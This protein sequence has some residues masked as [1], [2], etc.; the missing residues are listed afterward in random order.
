ME[1]LYN[2]IEFAACLVDGGLAVVFLWL[3]CGRKKHISKCL[4]IVLSII[5]TLI[6]GC[7]AH[8]ITTMPIQL[9]GLLMVLSIYSYFL[10]YGTVGKKTYF[11]ILWNVLLMMSSF[12]MVYGLSAILGIPQDLITQPASTTRVL[13]LI[14]HKSLL[15]CIMYIVFVYNK[16]YKFDYKQWLITVA[17]FLSVLSVGAIFIEL[18]SR[19]AFDDKSSFEIVLIAIILSIM[20]VVVCICQHILNIQNIYKV[21][22]DRLKSY[23]E[24]EEHDIKR[25]EEMYEASSII[26]HD[27]KHY[28]LVMNN[29][30]EEEKYNDLK[31]MIDELSGDRLL[32]A[33]VI[34]T[35]DNSLNA[36]LNNKLAVCKQ[37]G[38]EFQVQISCKI[39]KEIMIDICVIM[40]NLLDN[41]IEAEKQEGNGYI[42]TNISMRGNMLCINVV[43]KIMKPVL[44]NNPRLDTTKK[45]KDRHGF[46]LRSVSRRVEELDGIYT[47]KEEEGEFRT[48][49]QIPVK[50]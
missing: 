50:L 30:L 18:Y 49:I 10:L 4:H 29:M 14:I 7:I 33:N 48:I 34:Y 11:I 22:N 1:L 6:M 26:R 37:N 12:F 31:T 2:I 41:A 28:A 23:L 21:E 19:N 36:V 17:Q 25:I 15:V 47:Y 27:M 42:K 20:C 45:D 8:F 5:V 13:M 32:G 35:S 9:V 38:I 24:E 46:G 44:K 40:S 16:K 3:L 43:N 39:P